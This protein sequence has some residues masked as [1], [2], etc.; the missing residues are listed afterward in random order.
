[1]GAHVTSVANWRASLASG[2]GGRNH[3]DHCGARDPLFLRFLAVCLERKGV[4]TYPVG[5]DLPK[6]QHKG[7]VRA[8][9]SLRCGVTAA[10]TL[11]A[12]LLLQTKATVLQN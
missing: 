11:V 10:K 12:K 2:I 9:F 1:M 4:K 8:L 6:G 5:N 3:A 7:K